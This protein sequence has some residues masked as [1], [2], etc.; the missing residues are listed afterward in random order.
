MVVAPTRL[1]GY[2]AEDEHAAAAV[3]TPFVEKVYAHYYAGIPNAGVPLDAANF[4][5]FGVSTT[6]TIALV[7]R[8]GIVRLYHPGAMDEKSLR[9]AI[10][11]LL[12]APS[13]SRPR[14]TAV[15]R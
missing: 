7:D 9:A 13:H 11:P 5:R 15:T 8:R 14:G 12:T 2:T 1:Y 4:E 3:E 10:E 6:P